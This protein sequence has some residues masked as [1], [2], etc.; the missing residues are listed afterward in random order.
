MKRR[1]KY[2]LLPLII[3][4]LLMSGCSP[5]PSKGEVE[6]V[7]VKHFE[8][9]KYKVVELSISDINPLPL[10]EKKYMGTP[11]Y[12]VNVPTLILEMTE[13][14]GAPW[15]YRKGQK[16]FFKHVQISIQQS[17]GQNKKWLISNISGVSV[18]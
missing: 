17:T 18:P 14:T 6:E 2:A 16:V 8:T 11:A 3:I 15:N 10:S 9:K 12:T 5:A 7:I 4:L 1:R 13:E